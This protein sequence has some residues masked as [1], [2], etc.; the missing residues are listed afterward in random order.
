MTTAKLNILAWVDGS[1]VN[2]TV[3]TGIT[4]RTFADR[5]QLEASLDALS[6]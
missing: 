3:I 6:L 1:I 4:F 5:G 2:G